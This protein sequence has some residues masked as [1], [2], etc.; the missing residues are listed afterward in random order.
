MSDDERQTART[1]WERHAKNYDRSMR[2]LG[3]PLPRMLELVAREVD[4]ARDV[5][6]VGSGTGIVTIALARTAARVVATDYAQA[7]VDATR[8]RVR[9]AGLSN[10]EPVLASVEALPFP[11]Q[12]FDAVVAANVLHLVPDMN[13]ALAAI[14]RVLRPHGKVI[15]PTY[16][17]VQTRVARLVSRAL[18][19]TRFPGRRRLTLESLE[20]AVKRAGVELTHSEVL[21]GLLPIGFVSGRR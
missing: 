10:V 6:E 16:C 17:H 4:G 18:A 3:G 14:V 1:Y 2:V 19:L 5:L 9:E 8:R 12:S 7:M 20:G 13:A 21:P 11:D 15:V